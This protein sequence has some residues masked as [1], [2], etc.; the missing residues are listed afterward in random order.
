MET[1]RVFV[2]TIPLVEILDDENPLAHHEVVADENAGNGAEKTGISDKPAENV[3]AV[4]RHQFPRLHEDAHGTG[5]EAA[6]AE[7]DAARG[8]VREIVSRGDDIGGDVDVERG[9]Q[10]R[11]HGE[12][13]GPGIAEACED[14]DGIPKSF[15]KNDQSGG[16]DGDADEGVERHGGGEAKRLADDLI[17]LAAGVAREI[18]NVQ[19]DGGPK[20]D[21]TGKRR[22]KEAEK[23][24]EG[25]E[26]RGRRQH[27]A[28]PAGF[29]PC[30]KQ[31][32]ESDEQKKR[33]G[34]ALQETNGFEAA[35]NHKLVKKPEKSKTNSRAVV[36]VGPA[37]RQGHDHGIDG[38]AA[39][40]GLNAEPAAG[41]Q[42]AQDRGD[43]SAENAKGCAGKYR[44]W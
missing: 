33:S 12:D 41:D 9:H 18:R 4:V 37:R 38:F 15:A 42:G 16:S 17:A 11:N 23:F 36:K 20:S 43:I 19:R 8:K 7:T 2:A 28:E 10:Q 3:A 6:D 27:G 40:P 13:D 29:F 5:D 39:D 1:A 22:N 30:P 44:K 32:S 35:H 14:R 26:F 25:L 21:H 24:S 34:D 31:Q